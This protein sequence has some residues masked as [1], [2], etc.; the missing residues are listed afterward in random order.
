VCSVSFAPDGDGF[1]LAMNRDER[2]S[3]GAALPPE[4]FERA[5]LAVLCPR[6]TT[7]GTW[8]GV[9]S[10][11]MAFSL[12]NW[13][14]KPDCVTQNPVSRGEVVRALLQ[15]PSR[16]EATRELKKLPLGRMNPF[17]LIV[18][19]AAEPALVEWRSCD[20]ELDALE[21]PWKRNHW[22][23]SGFDEERASRSRQR[24]CDRMADEL[25]D[26]KTVRKLHRSHVPK[27]GP[28]SLCMHSRVAGTVS[29]AEISVRGNC[30]RMYYVAGKPCSRAPRS[31]SL[32]RLEPPDVFRRAAV[33]DAIDAR[34]GTAKHEA[35]L[36]IPPA[37]PPETY[38]LLPGGRDAARPLSFDN[39]R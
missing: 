26:L 16:V 12:L 30:A 37:N 36:S 20:G 38:A 21:L 27:A 33:S 14:S 39:C 17:R 19:S 11:R 18:V 3:R 7:G 25:F 29:Y 31:T 22:F 9:N 5:G 8:I 15:T 2:L 24:V 6:E 4:V 1:I 13:H 23:S 32:L 34:G 10:A 35:I 28:F